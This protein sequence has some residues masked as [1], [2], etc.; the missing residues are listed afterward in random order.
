VTGHFEASVVFATRGVH[1][2]TARID[3]LDADSNTLHVSA[4]VPPT[5]LTLTGT[6]SA[7]WNNSHIDWTLD[8]GGYP[9]YSFH[10]WRMVNGGARTLAGTV[11]GF[12]RSFEEAVPP[13]ASITYEVDAVNFA[14]SAAAIAVSDTTPTAPVD[15]LSASIS[16]SFGCE[17]SAGGGWWWGVP[18]SASE[19]QSNHTFSGAPTVSGHV[20]SAGA[21]AAT[22]KVAVSISSWLYDYCYPGHACPTTHVY[23]QSESGL[24]TV[25]A[26]GSFTITLPTLSWTWG[27]GA[28]ATSQNVF[29]ATVTIDGQTFTGSNSFALTTDMC[30][31]PYGPCGGGF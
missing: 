7:R 8:D 21:P 27:G 30:G 22:R 19:I 10:V 26:D 13:G 3:L 29:Q 28:D 20:T 11:G 14:G 5:M 24:A 16:T 4:V 23:P 6:Q 18:S 17:C 12:A 15:A 31:P 1:S 2:L 25:A 9:A